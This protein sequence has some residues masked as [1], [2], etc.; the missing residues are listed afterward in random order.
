MH[1]WPPKKITGACSEPR[2]AGRLRCIEMEPE[3]QKWQ[4][5]RVAMKFEFGLKLRTCLTLWSQPHRPRAPVQWCLAAL[6]VSPHD[7]RAQSDFSTHHSQ[8][9][10]K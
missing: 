5:G 6:A 7:C 8:H 10:G 1:K 4:P 3:P 9:K 2:V